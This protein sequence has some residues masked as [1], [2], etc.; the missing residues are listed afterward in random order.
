MKLVSKFAVGM[1]T[2]LNTGPNAP[3][4]YFWRVMRAYALKPE[5]LVC[6]VVLVVMIFYLQAVDVW[7]RTLLG[8][9][10]YTLG[11]ST[12]KVSK[13]QFLVNNSLNNGEKLSWELREGYVAA[14]AV[15]GHR[16]RME[17]R[18]VVNDDISNTGVSL[19]AVFDGH[20]GEVRSHDEPVVT[21]NLIVV[22]CFLTSHSYRYTC[23]Y[24][25]AFTLDR[26]CIS[27]VLF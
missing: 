15:Q 10:Q 22:V 12:S 2:G 13:L 11:R 7:R 20:G 14:Y 27:I 16:A 1:P 19:F 21:R 4:G 8:R 26:D 5:V 24:C 9:I 17:D 25:E 18:F 23:I 3:L 6:G